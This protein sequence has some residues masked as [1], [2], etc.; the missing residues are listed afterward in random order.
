MINR[1]LIRF[2]MTFFTVHDIQKISSE[3]KLVTETAPPEKVHGSL[4]TGPSECETLLNM[5]GSA[6]GLRK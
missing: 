4:L 6:E 2:L 5:P 3:Q 1:L